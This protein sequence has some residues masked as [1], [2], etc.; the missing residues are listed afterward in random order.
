MSKTVSPIFKPPPFQPHR[1]YRGGHLQT[2]GSIGNRDPSILKPVQHII[3]V[4]D[5]DSIVLHE[6]K[7]DNWNPEQGSMLLIH[8]LS[9]CYEATYMVRLANRFF[10]AG[11]R[12][13][14]MDM[15][16]VGAGFD[17]SRNV[18][19]SGRSADVIAALTEIAR[20]T[21]SG[22]MM[23]MGV[24]LGAHQLL[25]AAS[26]IGAGLDQTPEWFDRLVRIATVAPPFNL[27][28]CSENMERLS[29]RLYNHFFI[30][31]L[32]ANVPPLV[33]QR[34][35]F[36]QFLAGRR[37]RTLLELDDLM[38]APLSGFSG[39]ADYYQQSTVHE[40]AKHNPVTTLV[41]AAADDPIVP[42]TNYTN[43][44]V[45]WPDTTTLHISRTGGHAAFIDRDRNSWMD[46]V[47][48]QWFS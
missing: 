2:I 41:L 3:S 47:I 19:H 44:D 10:D 14:R 29:R 12:V 30:R 21:A 17:L 20:Q 43:P 23:A 32:L 31:K 13:Y 8:G 33:R 39:A 5:G 9:G 25:L 26:R 11:I 22:P 6:D 48:V 37:P 45:H 1:L 36:Q 28:R 34:D 35:E 42:V 27:P 40:I 46:R 18:L 16:G 24:S 4:S 38:T 15:R 7:P